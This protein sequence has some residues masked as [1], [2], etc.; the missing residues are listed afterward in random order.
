MVGGSIKMWDFSAEAKAVNGCTHHLLIRR[1]R[2]LSLHF[3]SVETQRK[4]DVMSLR[5]FTPPSA[6]QDGSKIFSFN[7]RTTIF[8]AFVT[9]LVDQSVLPTLTICTSNPGRL[10]SRAKRFYKFKSSVTSTFWNKELWFDVASN[11]ISLNNHT[12]YFREVTLLSNGRR[13]C[14]I[15]PDILY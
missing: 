14:M 15:Y 7:V 6:I 2:A 8:K 5:S 10:L 3:I 1:W 12:L 13:L 4:D 11:M 9:S